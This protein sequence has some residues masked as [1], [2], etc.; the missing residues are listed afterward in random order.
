[1][2]G[3]PSL[4]FY[5]ENA[6]LYAA[7][8]RRLPE[9]QMIRFIE[10]LPAGARILELGCGAGGDSEALLARGFDVTPSDG[11]A[12]MA[13]EA[14]RRLGRPVLV[15]PFQQLGYEAEFDGIWAN[16]CLLHVPRNDLPDVLGRIIRALRPGGRF[17]ASFK[18]GGAE[19]L[20]RLGRYYNR[21][22]QEE[23]EALCR[24]AGF[25]EID[26]ET[27]SGGAFDGEPTTWL[28]LHAGLA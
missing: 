25:T 7:R 8:D 12:A 5:D 23:L 28:Y 2:T 27:V 11:S 3:D 17:Y 15:L 1:M 6:A 24:P 16:A 14:E 13:S 21:P 20:D 19:G 10:R 26:I 22:S 4:R 9:P 18:A